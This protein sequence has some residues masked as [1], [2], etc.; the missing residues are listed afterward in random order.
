M[1]RIVCGRRNRTGQ[2]DRGKGTKGDEV[3]WGEMRRGVQEETLDFNIGRLLFGAVLVGWMR[4]PSIHAHV[5]K[6]PRLCLLPSFLPTLAL[7]LCC[8]T[9][10]LS[11]PLS[12]LLTC[13]IHPSLWIP[14]LQNHPSLSPF[15]TPLLF[16]SLPIIHF[17]ASTHFRQDPEI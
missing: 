16:F 7:F 12:L 1:T 10:S 2:E 15:T 4:S 6:C 11:L 8:I 14:L 13:P 9:L 5:Y 3:S 17:C